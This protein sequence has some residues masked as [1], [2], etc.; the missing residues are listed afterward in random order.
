M[1]EKSDSLTDKEKK[2]LELLDNPKEQRMPSFTGSFQIFTN[3]LNPLISKAR[4]KERVAELRTK[5]RM[6]ELGLNEHN[7]W[8]RY[9]EIKEEEEKRFDDRFK[10]L[11]TMG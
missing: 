9:Y 5:M 10:D 4:R 7:D 11:P 2:E 8:K 3:F 1:K 6:S